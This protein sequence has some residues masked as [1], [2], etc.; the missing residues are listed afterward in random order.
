MR[1]EIVN[2]DEMKHGWT[3]SEV[4]MAERLLEY[5]SPEDTVLVPYKDGGFII[6]ER[7][8]FIDDKA[9]YRYMS[10]VS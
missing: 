2:K 3:R 4:Y 8:S 5:A 1:V 10:T 6:F 9:S 7:I